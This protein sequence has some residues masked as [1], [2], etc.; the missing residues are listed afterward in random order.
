MTLTLAIECQY[1]DR[2]NKG[3]SNAMEQILCKSKGL[4]PEKEEVHF[5]RNCYTVLSGVG[6][7]IDDKLKRKNSISIVRIN[8]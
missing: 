1:D 3:G 6:D 2:K 7:R 5:E 4:L 8:V